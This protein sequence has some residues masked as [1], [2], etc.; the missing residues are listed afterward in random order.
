MR[1][2]LVHDSVPGGE[3]ASA[4]L[5]AGH[6]IERCG[7]SAGTGSACRAVDGTCP[8]DGRI[9]VAVVR[10]DDDGERFPLAEAGVVCAVRD[11][12]PVVL[13]G[14]AAAP[15]YGG[16]VSTVATGP[17]DV[18]AACRRAADGRDRRLSRLVGGTVEVRGDRVLAHLPAGTPAAGAVAAH[19]ALA[20]A[21]PHARTVDV[22][23]G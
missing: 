16:H 22:A 18:D 1:I 23:V 4:L 15:A 7:G 9:D 14:D 20:D 12:V 17:A 2:L 21:L 8:L 6:T 13:V 19:R 10:H 5:R 11:H 3:V